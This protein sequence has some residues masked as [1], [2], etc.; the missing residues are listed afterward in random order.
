MIVTEGGKLELT[1]ASDFDMFPFG[2]EL[3]LLF[4]GL[5]IT[6]LINYYFLFPSPESPPSYHYHIL[7]SV[8]VSVNIRFGAGHDQRRASF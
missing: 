2:L 8:I 4:L 1:L 7:H 3:S 5:A 6:V